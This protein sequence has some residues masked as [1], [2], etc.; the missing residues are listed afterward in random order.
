MKVEIQDFII[1]YDKEISYLNDLVYT[2]ENNTRDILDFFDLDKISNKKKVVIY[3]DIEKYKEHLKPYVKEYDD[4]MCADTYDGNINLLDIDIARQTESHKYMTLDELL[5]VALHEFVH[6]CQQEIGFCPEGNEWFWETLS[7]NLS[8]QEFTEINLKDFDF[9]EFRE[10]F[11]INN[12]EKSSRHYSASYMIGKYMLENY[13]KDKI[14]EYIKYPNKL[15]EDTE[16]IF[17]EVKNI[18]IK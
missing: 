6:S 5:K 17:E 18:K 8:G 14:L 1:E 7:T 10:N 11:N 13:S 12:K 9:K 15:I 16:N 3:T 4:W 2:L